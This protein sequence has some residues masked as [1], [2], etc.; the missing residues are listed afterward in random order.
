M[1]NS[2]SHRLELSAFIRATDRRLC[3]IGCLRTFGY[4]AG[5]PANQIF[6]VF[7]GQFGEPGAAVSRYA[8]A[9]APVLD[10]LVGD[11]HLPR[12]L[13]DGTKLLDGSFKCFVHGSCL[14]ELVLKP[15]LAQAPLVAQETFQLPQAFPV[16]ILPL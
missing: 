14:N 3:I 1:K 10:S 13:S 2:E 11:F 16:V 15:T 6:A 5:L 12:H 7:A 8:T 4:I 9:L